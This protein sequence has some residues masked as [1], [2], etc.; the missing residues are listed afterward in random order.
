MALICAG[1][2]FWYFKTEQLTVSD[3]WQQDPHVTIGNVSLRVEIADTSAERRQGLSGRD[4]IGADGLLFVFPE[5]GHP[6]IWMKDMHFPIDILWLNAQ[7]TIVH[8]EQN[9]SPE[10]Y[11]TVFRSP[12]PA[13]Y[14]LETNAYYT[15]TFGIKTGQTA[16]L[17]DEAVVQN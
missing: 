17:P 8:I 16:I 2:L 1:I 9:V 12:Q 10:T 4:R 7:G 15:S 5:D 14:V 13:R 6:G 3:L 11:P